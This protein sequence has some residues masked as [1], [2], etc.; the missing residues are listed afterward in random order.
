M[1]AEEQL[2]ILL[3]G[4]VDYHVPEEFV[5]KLEKSRAENK[6]LRVKLG[7]DPT[8]P[9][10]HLGHLVVLRKLRQFQDLGHQ[11]VFLVGDFT[12]RI[13]DP[14]GKSETR[15]PLSAEQVAANAKT[16]TEQV[17]KILDRDKTEIVFNS[18][19]LGKM[20]AT[21]LISL[22]AKYTVARMLERDDFKKRYSTGRAISVHEFLY[23]LL[24][25]YDSV[26]I[27]ADVELG[28]SDQLFNLLVGRQLQKEYGQE[29]QIVLTLPLLEGTDARVEDGKIVGAKMSKSLGNYVG[30]SEPCD[31]VYG[32]LMSICDE[33]MWRYYD[34]L[35]ECSPEEIAHRKANMHPM[36]AKHALAAE[37]AG[38]FNPADDVQKA[39][40]A[41]KAQFSAKSIPQ[42]L[43]TV[44]L[45]AQDGTLDLI[46]VLVESKLA[47]SSSEA[48]RLIQGGGVKRDGTEAYTDIQTKLPAGEYILKVGKRRWAKIIIK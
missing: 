31:V 30:I 2:K 10:L 42:D 44:T 16:Y 28:G 47:P 33:L 37:I 5:K 18:T 43:D 9:D 20:D 3:R 26:A 7:A 15:K 36:E 13:G 17:F 34:L 41:W 39:Q 6:P 14:T 46:R 12:S 19:W 11:V 32:K 48:R 24:Q 35:S 27:H 38:W 1:P 23:P 8:A 45:T 22:A 40:D 25:G 4:V 21:D 29:S